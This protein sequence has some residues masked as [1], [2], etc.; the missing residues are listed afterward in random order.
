MSVQSFGGTYDGRVYACEFKYVN[1]VFRLLEV[2]TGV[3]CASVRSDM[4]TQFFGDT[5]RGRMC[6]YAFIYVH[7]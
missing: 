4:P 6:V 1:L 2:L 5:H 3:G 7:F